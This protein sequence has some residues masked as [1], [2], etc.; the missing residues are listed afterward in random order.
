[1]PLAFYGV[2][3]VALSRTERAA[4]IMHTN[5]EDL[6]WCGADA[7]VPTGKLSQTFL[8]RLLS[9]AELPFEKEIPKDIAKALEKRFTDSGITKKVKEEAKSR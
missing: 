2:P 9:A 1:M 5:L 8:E 4:Q 3:S 7:F 6:R